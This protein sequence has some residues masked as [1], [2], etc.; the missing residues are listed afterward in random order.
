MKNKRYGVIVAGCDGIYCRKFILRTDT[1]HRARK[2]AGVLA[3]IIKGQAV[4]VVELIPGRVIGHGSI[5]GRPFTRE[6]GGGV[7]ILEERKAAMV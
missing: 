3:K 1:L 5:E 4:A 6:E 7:K 2:L